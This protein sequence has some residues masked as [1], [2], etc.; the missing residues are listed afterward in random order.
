MKYI[1]ENN[2]VIIK[3]LLFKK[4]IDLPKITKVIWE[5]RLSFFVNEKKVLSCKVDK[6]SIEL[7]EMVYD[8]YNC[9]Q[10]EYRRFFFEN[11][12]KIP[13]KQFEEELLQKVDE[14]KRI[15][16]K[17]NALFDFELCGDIVYDRRKTGAMY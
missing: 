15:V 5:K 8:Q 13:Y 4:Q 14:L 16:D 9:E 2:T 1:Y 10:M 11:W 7:V 3:S 17:Y 12:R 6:Q